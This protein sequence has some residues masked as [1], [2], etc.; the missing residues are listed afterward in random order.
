MNT[1]D[2]P[3]FKIEEVLLNDAEAHF[4]LGTFSQDIADKTINKLRERAN[5][6]K[7]KVDEIDDSFDPNPKQFFPLLKGGRTLF[8]VPV[9]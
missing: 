7:M 1:S 9:E 5:V 6:A 3:I 8:F 4:E 2:K